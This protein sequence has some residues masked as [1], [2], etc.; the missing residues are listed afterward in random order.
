MKKKEIMEAPAC[1]I[2][3]T[4]NAPC[5]LKPKFVLRDGTRC[6]TRHYNALKADKSPPPPP[7]RPAE[8]EDDEVTEYEAGPVARQ[9][10]T[11]TTTT[12][13][14]SPW[15]VLGIVSPSRLNTKATIKKITTKLRVGPDAK[16]NKGGE[17]YCYY[18][19]REVGKNYWKIGMTE[20][21]ADKRLDEWSLEHGVRV[22]LKKKWRIRKHVKY[23]ERII[24]L[25]LQYARMY[26]M[27]VA[28]EKK[29]FRSIMM[30]SKLV[31]EMEEEG[32][33]IE[34]AVK[35]HV[36]W[37]Y[38][39]WEVIEFVIESLLLIPSIAMN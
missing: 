19:P 2:L 39:Q 16:D 21:S 38:E 13:T 34:Q 23:A 11:T 28:G 33:K 24:H 4:K 32:E 6:C 10:T 26:R 5:K 37:F 8:Q 27:P 20:R 31:V 12:T 14:I 30:D 9:A 36:E 1:Q 25:Y 35:K 29:G 15:I 17:I 7:R 18:L 3:T 22:V